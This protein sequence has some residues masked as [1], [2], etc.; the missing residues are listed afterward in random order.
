M[1][2]CGLDLSSSGQSPEIDSCEHDNETSG[3]IKKECGEFLNHEF[4]CLSSKMIER[5][6]SSCF[7]FNAALLS[8]G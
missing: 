4:P 3:S 7:S 6:S 2:G 1:R 8:R 5:C